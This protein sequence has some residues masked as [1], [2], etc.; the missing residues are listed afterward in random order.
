[1]FKDIKE[2]IKDSCFELIDL[3]YLI[4]FAIIIIIGFLLQILLVFCFDS[5]SL[6][7]ICLVLIPI[8]IFVRKK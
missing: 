3:V 6:A 7:I 8:L 4:L 5:K 1:M 2:F